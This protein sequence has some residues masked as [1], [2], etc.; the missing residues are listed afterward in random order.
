MLTNGII[1]PINLSFLKTI[2]N[3]INKSFLLDIIKKGFSSDIL[4]F[5][6]SK[7][8]IKTI[9][10]LLLFGILSLYY[11][12]NYYAKSA[13]MSKKIFLEQPNSIKFAIL[14]LLLC[15]LEIFM[16]YYH[17]KSMFNNEL[18]KYIVYS[19]IFYLI[20]TM[21]VSV[22][23]YKEKISKNAIIGYI[24]CIVGIIIIKMN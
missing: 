24:L 3:I 19:V 11:K 20:F 9:G 17:F 15:I 10:Y 5:L 2:H 18:N 16:G 4:V 6:Y 8:F 1:Y 13:Q 22:I 21:I 23:L 7:H 14:F 12:K